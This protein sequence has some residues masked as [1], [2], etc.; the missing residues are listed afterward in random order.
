MEAHPLRANDRPNPLQP[1]ASLNILSHRD[2]HE[3]MLRIES[4]AACRL[5][6][7]FA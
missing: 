5:L 6:A 7:R 4:P 1:T 3:S 2:T